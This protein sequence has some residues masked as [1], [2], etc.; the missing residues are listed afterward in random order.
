MW[1]RPAPTQLWA[2]MT[3]LAFVIFPP[4]RTKLREQTYFCFMFRPAEH[5]HV[6]WKQHQGRWVAGRT[7]AGSHWQALETELC[8][9]L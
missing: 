4:E 8:P 7:R 3:F 5:E 6:S 9:M 1:G 2:S